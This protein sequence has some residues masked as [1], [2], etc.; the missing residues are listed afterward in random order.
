ML[1][2]S[3]LN[4]RWCIHISRHIL[5]A[6]A[7]KGFSFSNRLSGGM[8]F[9]SFVLSQELT[10]CLFFRKSVGVLVSL[11]RCIKSCFFMW[12]WTK[13]A[14][15]TLMLLPIYILIGIIILNRDS[16]LCSPYRNILFCH[17]YE[18]GAKSTWGS[19]AEL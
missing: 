14:S 1:T 18:L 13:E 19:W 4:K 17:L 10:F 6:A 11:Y 16:Y 8:E 9:D 15:C 7:L 5:L 12:V 2:F 3:F